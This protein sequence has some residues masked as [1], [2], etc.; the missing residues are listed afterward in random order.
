MLKSFSLKEF[1]ITTILRVKFSEKKEIWTGICPLCHE[2][3]NFQI[4][5][6]LGDF[7]RR[8]YFIYHCSKCDKN[9]LVIVEAEDTED[10][11]KAK[12]NVVKR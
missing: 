9:T 7:N 10:T 8:G 12:L 5:E 11:R 3:D 1:K 6:F 2:K 4:S